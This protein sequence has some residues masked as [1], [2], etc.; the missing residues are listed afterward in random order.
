MSKR[1]R[2][3]TVA[4]PPGLEDWYSRVMETGYPGSSAVRRRFD[5]SL[6]ELENRRPR[7][8]GGTLVTPFAVNHGEPGG[9]S[10]AYRIETEGRVIAYTGDTE[11]TDALIEAG[12]DAD[13]FISEA[14]FYDK[15]VK[16][17]LDFATLQK[18]LPA[19]KP[20]RVILTHMSEDMLGRLADVPC[21]TADDGM[22]INL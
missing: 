13:L 10:F 18:H 2:P 22:V 3:L 16:L 12:R 8:I 6:V 1:T 21:E 4:G 7:E 9:P 19:I 5:L 14:Y 11:W 15:P 20:K 17:H